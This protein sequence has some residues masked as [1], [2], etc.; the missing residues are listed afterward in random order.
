M[1]PSEY[2]T[3]ADLETS[4]WWYRAQH[5]AVTQRLDSLNLPVTAKLLDAGCGTG[6][7]LAFLQSALSISSMELTGLEWHGHAARLAHSKTGAP[8][9]QGN[10]CQLP[11]GDNLF[12]VVL[13]QDVLYH[14][15]VNET[16]ALNSVFRCLQPGGW[17]LLSLPAYQW[18][19]SAH[20]RH[21]HGARR[22]TA[23]GCQQLLENAGFIHVR[24]GYW[25]SLLFPLMALQRMTTGKQQDKSDVRALPH[26]LNHLLFSVLDFERRA[27]LQLPFGGSVWAQA[28]KPGCSQ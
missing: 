11:F 22:Y 17:L 5:K 1:E 6:G 7:M 14:K 26:W 18:M 3:M 12:D 25:N 15:N 20:D 28:M 9:V 10:V 19:H 16:D 13:S 2:E 8:V 21:V 27:R 4:F 23:S 24:T